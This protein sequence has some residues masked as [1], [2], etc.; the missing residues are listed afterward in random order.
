MTSSRKHLP[1]F[2]TDGNSQG[3]GLDRGLHFAAGHAQ[4]SRGSSRF[5][6]GRGRMAPTR[7]AQC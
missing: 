7:E 4:R 3:H 1:P 2:A 5:L 6:Y